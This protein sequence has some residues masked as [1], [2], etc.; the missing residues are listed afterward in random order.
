VTTGGCE[1]TRPGEQGFLYGLRRRRP[2][3]WRWEN[4]SLRMMVEMDLD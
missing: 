3:R 2:Y 4:E 1:L